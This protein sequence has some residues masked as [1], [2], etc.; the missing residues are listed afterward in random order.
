M[1][2]ASQ[3]RPAGRAQ[4][5]PAAAPNEKGTR[6]AEPRQVSRSCGGFLKAVRTAPGALMLLAA[7]L[8]AVAGPVPRSSVS[9]T[10][11]LAQG[12]VASALGAELGTDVSLRLL[13]FS[14][15]PVPE[16]KLEFP[17]SGLQLPAVGT[18]GRPLFWR[19]LVRVSASRTVPV[20]ARVVLSVSRKTVVARSN[21]PAG[22]RIPAESIEAVVVAALPFG[23]AALDDPGKAAGKV[24]RRSVRAGQAVYPEMLVEA[25]AVERGDRIEATATLGGASLGFAAVA[26]SAGSSGE[27]ITVTNTQTGKHLRAV[28]EGPGKV[29]VIETNKGGRP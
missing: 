22:K 18:G 13:E 14:R 29:S 12:E 11:T 5:P 26:E 15:Y 3:G 6:P 20:W 4:G 10:R 28:V 1:S 23:E 16:G 24:L 27:T 8:C 21:L 17:K 2:L 19:G 7:V 9:P 25:R